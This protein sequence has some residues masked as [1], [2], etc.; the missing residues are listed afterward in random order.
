MKFYPVFFTASLLFFPC[1]C[2]SLIVGKERTNLRVENLTELN[3]SNAIRPNLQKKYYFFHILINALTY[4][5][6]GTVK[7]QTSP[8]AYR[9]VN[10][11]SNRASV[12]CRVSPACLTPPPP[13][14]TPPPPYRDVSQKTLRECLLCVILDEWQMVGGVYSQTG[15]GRV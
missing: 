12:Q 3:E 15:Y 7:Y 9:K 2:E 14:L 5:Q 11:K 8:V 10:D 4:L 1:I 6:K 13:R